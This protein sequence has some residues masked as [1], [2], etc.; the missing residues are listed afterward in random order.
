MSMVDAPQD[1]RPCIMIRDPER[2]RRYNVAASRA[3]DQLWLFH[4]PTLNDLRP[5]CLRY[6]L[7]H[8]C[9]HPSVEQKTGP[10]DIEQIRRL[11]NSPDRVGSMPPQPFDSWFEVDVYLRVVDRQYRVTP[12]VPV[13]GYRI[14]LVVEGL[15]GRLALECDGDEWHGEDAFES[16]SRRQ[17]NLERCG[18]TFVRIRGG[19]F[20]RDPD[21]ALAP[22]WSK[23]D[24]LNIVRKVEGDAR[25][26]VPNPENT[27]NDSCLSNF[28]LPDVTDDAIADS[29]EDTQ[30]EV[31][32]DVTQQPANSANTVGL[33]APQKAA[34]SATE[35]VFIEDNSESLESAILSLVNSKPGIDLNGVIKT[36]VDA[37]VSDSKADIEYCVEKCINHGQLAYRGF[38]IK[39]FIANSK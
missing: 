11:A 6:A 25:S 31:D 8:H 21:N 24:E 7:L 27:I 13:A 1:G 10:I 22:L 28:T 16:D 17:R 26:L 23:L 33:Q 36:L 38:A 39:L 4:T 15:Q 35:S 29:D 3:K 37:R 9:L 32:E 18:W 12:Q 14:D 5:E 20:Y 34:P 19:A 2:M 30:D